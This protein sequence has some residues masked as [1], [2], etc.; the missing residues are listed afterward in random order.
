MSKFVHQ[1]MSAILTYG[2][3]SKKKNKK[4]TRSIADFF[5]HF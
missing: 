5:G 1:I 4:K 3:N 2:E